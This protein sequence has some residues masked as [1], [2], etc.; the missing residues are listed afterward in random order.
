[1]AVKINFHVGKNHFFL[2]CQAQT[3]VLA[4]RA[5]VTL[6]FDWLALAV[7]LVLV[8]SC[9]WKIAQGTHA[10]FQIQ[11]PTKTSFTANASQSNESVSCARVASADIFAGHRR[12]IDFYHHGN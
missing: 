4:T 12:K 11:L 8:G 6:T 7:K 2:P 1:M 9:I 10:I 5:G 3:S